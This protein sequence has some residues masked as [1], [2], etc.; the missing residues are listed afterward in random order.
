MEPKLPDLSRVRS[1]YAFCPIHKDYVVAISSSPVA[2]LFSCSKCKYSNL[3]RWED[4]YETEI[5]DEE[6]E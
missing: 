2:V 3:V 4:C 1:R 5:G 6:A